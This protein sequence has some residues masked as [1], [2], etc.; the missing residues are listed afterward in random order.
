MLEEDREKGDMRESCDQLLYSCLLFSYHGFSDLLSFSLLLFRV[1][2]SHFLSHC[3]LPL[4]YLVY[5]CFLLAC[6]FLAYNVTSTILLL[7]PAVPFGFLSSNPAS[8][9]RSFFL[10]YFFL[11]LISFNSFYILSFLFASSHFILFCLI[12]LFSRFFFSNVITSS[13]LVS[14]PFW[15]CSHL[16][17]SLFPLRLSYCISSCFLSFPCLS[18]IFRYFAFFSG[19]FYLIISSFLVFFFLHLIYLWSLPSSL[20]SSNIISFY[21]VCSF[22]YFALLSSYLPS[23]HHIFLSNF[24]SLFL[25]Y[26]FPLIL[27]SLLFSPC[28]VSFP[29]LSSFP[30]SSSWGFWPP[31]QGHPNPVLCAQPLIDIVMRLIP[32]SLPPCTVPLV[33]SS[34][35]PIFPGT[36]SHL[37]FPLCSLSPRVARLIPFHHTSNRPDA[38]H[39]GRSQGLQHLH[40]EACGHV[41]VRVWGGGVYFSLRG[42][43]GGHAVLRADVTGT[44]TAG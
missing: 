1:F 7:F 21:L 16:L 31:V 23:F 9:H 26:F 14:F 29:L 24:L 25:D 38:L 34:P 17:F 12:Y 13:L 2:S 8:C 5:I 41:Y 44:W 42:L 6:S 11:S 43:E 22:N 30:S 36:L 37:L 20:F 40:R 27:F 4:I 32:T 15:V 3:L 33:S 19:P 39:A 18:S 35:T 10:S 28:L